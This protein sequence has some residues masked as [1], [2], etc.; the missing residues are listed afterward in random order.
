MKVKIFIYEKK[1]SLSLEWL[2]IEHNEDAQ[3][4]DL[5]TELFF[6]LFF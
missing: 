1:S 3:N 6:Y 4:E 5:V 2:I